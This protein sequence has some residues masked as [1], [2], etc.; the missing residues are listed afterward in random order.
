MSTKWVL[1]GAGLFFVV[2]QSGGDTRVRTWLPEYP[3]SHTRGVLAVHSYDGENEAFTF[4][5]K[6]SAGKVT[7]FYNSAFQSAGLSVNH[8][9][10][11]SGAWEAHFVAAQDGARRRVAL[12]MANTDGNGTSVKVTYTNK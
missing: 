9:M 7:K 10:F 11:V 6:D 12:V 1:I 3:E 8:G 2:I 4:T 5:T